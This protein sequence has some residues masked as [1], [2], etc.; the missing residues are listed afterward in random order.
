MFGDINA[1]KVYEIIGHNN[2]FVSPFSEPYG[3][4]LWITDQEEPVDENMAEL[5]LEK[6]KYASENVD[7]L[8]NQAVYAIQSKIVLSKELREKLIF[9]SFVLALYDKEISCCL[10]NPNFMLGHFIEC[11]WDLNWKLIFTY[12]C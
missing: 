8:I 3:Y 12:Y 10:S 5:Y 7:L 4:Y 9:E 2:R 11:R 1:T 6:L